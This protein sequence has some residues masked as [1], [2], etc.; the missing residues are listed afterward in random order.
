MSIAGVIVVLGV[1]VVVLVVWLGFAQ[2]VGRASDAM[3][4]TSR[5]EHGDAD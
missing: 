1:V 5:V 4:R 2:L 3:R